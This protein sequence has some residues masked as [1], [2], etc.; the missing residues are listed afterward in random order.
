M[1][2]QLFIDGVNRRT[3]QVS[4]RIVAM[5][6]AAIIAIG[7]LGTAADASAQWGN[8]QNLFVSDPGLPGR[9]SV[10]N[11]EYDFGDQFLN[12]PGYPVPSEMRGS[13][14][15]PAEQ[16]SYPLIVILH[17]R[18]V[19]SFNALD[20][21]ET[22]LVWPPQPGFV[23]IDNHIGHSVLAEHLASHGFV[24]ATI[25]AN[26]I[27]SVDAFF[28]LDSQVARARLI[29]E[30]INFLLQANSDSTVAPWE[31]ALV[32][33]IDESRIG[34][35]GHSRGAEA[36]LVNTVINNGEG[37]LQFPAAPDPSVFAGAANDP[38]LFDI[39]AVMAVSPTADLQFA[40][41]DTPMAVVL[42]YADGDTDLR[43]AAHYDASP[44]HTNLHRCFRYQA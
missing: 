30:H 2:I 16:G 27:A 32:G 3:R 34:L 39:D 23:R 41:H 29:Q 21:N 10:Q 42:G 5:T 13:V 11:V 19:S 20:F 14:F 6:A 15:F 40:V 31:S 1:Q 43:G 22:S 4:H 28:P 35:L 36:V 18:H 17:G 38:A 12:I 8:W 26:A 24:V 33:K 9:N 37:A 44:V 25:S 7:G